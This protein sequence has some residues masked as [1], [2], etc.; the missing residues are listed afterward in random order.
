MTCYLVSS[1]IGAVFYT[2]ILVHNLRGKRNPWVITNVVLLLSVNVANLLALYPI[3]MIYKVQEITMSVIWQ[4]AI[5][6]S[7]CDFGLCVEHFL[8]A[9]KYRKMSIEQPAKLNNLPEV[10]PTKCEDAVY[11]IMLF[12]NGIFPI[13]ETFTLKDTTKVYYMNG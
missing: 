2:A 1:A 13:L 6:W 9:V 4:Y 12:L 5:T 3:Y 7:V 11:Y 10:K 8:L